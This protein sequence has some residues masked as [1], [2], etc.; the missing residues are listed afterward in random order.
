MVARLLLFSIAWLFLSAPL[1]ARDLA[2]EH[3]TLVDLDRFGTSSHDVR[4]VVVVVRDGR[5]V[6]A[7]PRSRVAVPAGARRID[8]RGKWII[9]GLID[10]FSSQLDT[11]QA[12]AQLAMGVTTISQTAD[13]DERRGPYAPASPQPHM[14]RL[15]G[16][17]GYDDKG[18]GNRV[19]YGELHDRGRRL[20]ETELAADMDRQIG[21]GAAGFMLMYPLDDAQVAAAVRHARTRGLFTIGELGHASYAKAAVAGVDAFIHTSR[22]ELELTPPDLHEAVA[23]APFLP[24]TAPL[25]RRYSEFLATLDTNNPAFHAYAATLVRHGT[26]L[27]PTL[28]IATTY[29]PD[30]PN[31]WASKIGL[32]IARQS[33][34]HLPFDEHTGRAPIPADAPADY[35]AVREARARK[36]IATMHAFHQA[37]VHFL[38]GSGAVA[39][40]VLP[41]WGLHRELELL[42]QCGL[43]PREALA[44]ATTNFADRFRW[45][46]VG[47]I[48]PGYRAD[49]VV[50]SAD[51]T[52]DIRNAQAIDA[53]YLDGER[54]NL[55]RLLAWRPAG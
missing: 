20:S 12:Y 9:P 39:F 43:S 40:G 46:D 4:D 47:R 25:T 45:R 13:D 30:T 48:A 55:E 11:G 8:L 1:A 33:I 5:V 42:V 36:S 49:L 2:L 3:A 41:G 18:L 29:L 44:A 26:A 22:I 15:G 23:Q 52:R 53:V 37:G 31:P 24:A 10:G 35:A 54:L 19:G 51:P 6:A 32:L 50:L 21:E 34:R 17:V 28:A 16:V 38:A 7:G 27:M 14:R